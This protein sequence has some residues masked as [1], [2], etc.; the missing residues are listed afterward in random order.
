MGTKL[1]IAVNDLIIRGERIFRVTGVYLGTGATEDLVGIRSVDM[2]PGSVNGKT[3]SE[4]LLP[5]AL[6]N[7][8]EIYRRV[9]HSAL[10]A[11][12]AVKAA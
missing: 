8:D 3:V 12:A 11:L 5:L 6:M 4:M 2:Q 9:N 1:N 7:P 10:P